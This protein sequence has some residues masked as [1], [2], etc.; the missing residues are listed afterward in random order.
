MHHILLAVD[1][2]TIITAHITLE[3]GNEV[4]R[5]IQDFLYKKENG[6][7]VKLAIS[8]IPD[9]PQLPLSCRVPNSSRL[10]FQFPFNLGY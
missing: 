2:T 4:M 8:A 9:G 3:L 6:Y 10:V 5:P 1:Q 7:S